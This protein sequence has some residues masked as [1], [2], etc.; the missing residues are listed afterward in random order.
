MVPLDFPDASKTRGT[1]AMRYF[2]PAYKNTPRPA[3]PHTI[4]RPFPPGR[5]LID[6]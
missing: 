4:R 6:C 3:R 2:S 5:M 1:A